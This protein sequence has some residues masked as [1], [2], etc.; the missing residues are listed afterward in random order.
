MFKKVREGAVLP[1]RATKLSAGYDFALAE[2]ITIKAGE[3]V[4]IPS[5]IAFESEIEGLCLKLYPRSSMWAKY[6]LVMPYVG[7]IDGDFMDEIFF[8]FENTSDVDIE[9]KAGQRVAQGIFTQWFKY[10]GEIEPTEE[11]S[12]GHGSTGV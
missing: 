12:G 3:K 10:E 4:R 7:V 11:R 2:D 5:G 6:G 1:R 9:L 8:P